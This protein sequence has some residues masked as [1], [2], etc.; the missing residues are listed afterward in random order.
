MT[1]TV[2]RDLSPASWLSDSDLPWGRL[3][4]FG[5]AGFEAYARLRILPDPQRPGQSEAEAVVEPWRRDQVTRL[6]RALAA[7]T[8]TP[9]DCWF[10]VWEGYGE[11]GGVA[12]AGMP[13]VYRDDGPAEPGPGARPARHPGPSTSPAPG[14]PTVALPHRA[15]WLFHGRLAEHGTW[16]RAAGWPGPPLHAPEAA[17]VW[18]A[19]HAWCV[20]QDVDAHWAG[21]GACRQVLDRLA[22]DPLLDVV[23]ADPS[24]EQPSYA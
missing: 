19:D 13:R 3:V 18:P 8:A 1:L 2:C 6:L 21:I 12:P 23:P 16:A 20:A 22:A 14:V 10:C 11:S 9:E 5:P 7:H 4:G 17:F 24:A 15:Y